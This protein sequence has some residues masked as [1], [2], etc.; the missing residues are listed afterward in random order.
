M[1]HNVLLTGYVPQS[2]LCLYKFKY[3]DDPAVESP[4]APA[5]PAS[6]VGAPEPPGFK[7]ACLSEVPLPEV[8]LQEY[9]SVSS[10]KMNIASL[11]IFQYDILSLSPL[12]FQHRYSRQSL[13]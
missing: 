6:Y 2:H 7:N 8:Q 12:L 11:K 9:R 5:Y 3:K 13:L 10:T 4:D 1:C